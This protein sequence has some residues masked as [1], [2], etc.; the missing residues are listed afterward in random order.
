MDLFVLDKLIINF[1]TRLMD[2]AQFQ[3]SVLV[4]LWVVSEVV[5]PSKKKKEQ[6]K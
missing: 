2:D 5:F 1:V 6:N 4:G 3:F